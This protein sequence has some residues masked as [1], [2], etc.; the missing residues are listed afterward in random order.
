MGCKGHARVVREE[1][2]MVL[3]PIGKGFWKGGA[4]TEA[5]GPC[6]LIGHDMLDPKPCKF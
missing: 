1:R 2:K 3:M 4:D 5:H 6:Y